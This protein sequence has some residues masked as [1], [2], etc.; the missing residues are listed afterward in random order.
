MTS[1]P[2]PVRAVAGTVAGLDTVLLLVAG[3][4]TLHTYDQISAY[5][6]EGFAS[7]GYLLAGLCA[8]VALPSLVLAVVGL[9]ARGAVAVAC[10]ILSVL[11]LV[12]AIVFAVSWV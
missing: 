2:L 7:L 10:T 1:T 9:R 12:A 3:L 11:V 5:G 6:D 8:V 4:I